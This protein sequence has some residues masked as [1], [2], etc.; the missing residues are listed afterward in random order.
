MARVVQPKGAKGS[1]K[2]IQ[3]LVNAR[4]DLINQ[5]IAQAINLR[6]NDNIH[7]LSPLSTDEYAEYRDASFTQRLGI[8]LNGRSRE[9]FWPDHGPQWDALGKTDSGKVL[10]VEAKAHLGEIVS[11][12]TQASEMSRKKIT[13]SLK[14][15][16]VFLNVAPNID[17][18]TT[19]YQYAN[20]LA[21]LYL[22]RI[23]NGIDS[24]LVFVYFLNDNE[25]E[26]PKTVR[27][28]RAAIM[29]LEAS[30]GLRKHK[31]SRFIL[32][33]FIDVTEL[34]KKVM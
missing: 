28:W 8:T 1:L 30:L 17:W 5:Q 6:E 20:R 23:L 31:L 24:Y 12:G 21:H 29:V 18:S 27:E 32:E 25:V 34:R 3:R 11:P 2:W 7:W 10:L 14:E 19:F 15:T 22:L 26:G 4:P 16:K 9:S 33:V 13:S